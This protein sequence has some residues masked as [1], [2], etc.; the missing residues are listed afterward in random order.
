MTIKVIAESHVDHGIAK[1]ALQWLLDRFADRDGFFIETVELPEE[2]GMVPCGLHGPLMGDEPIAESEVTYKARGERGY[3]SRLADRPARQVRTVT[4]I[5]GP[6][7]D[8]PCVLYTAFGGPLTPQEPGDPS[9]KDLKE[10]Q[11]FWST[12][13]LSA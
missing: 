12:H 11:Q 10:S 9:C 13:A 4:V 2:L 5:A 6:D 1:P 8:E 7:G 3:P